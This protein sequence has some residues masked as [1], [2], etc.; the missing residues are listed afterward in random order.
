MDDN[1]DMDYSCIEEDENDTIRPPDPVKKECLIDNND[2]YNYEYIPYRQPLNIINNDENTSDP[3]EIYQKELDKIIE[4]SKKEFE[5]IGGILTQKQ[6]KEQIN[7]ISSI[8]KKINKLLKIDKDNQYYY[9]M[10]LTILEMYTNN[11]IEVYNANELEIDGLFKILKQI[12]LTKE[13]F[14]LLEKIIQ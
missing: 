2:E 9:E 4:L 8:N 12:R 14:E 13:E 6:N 3:E 1:Y 10:I 11:Y 7:I 5:E